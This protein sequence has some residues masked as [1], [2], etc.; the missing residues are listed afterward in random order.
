MS[1][2]RGL[3][4]ILFALVTL[5]VWGDDLVLHGR[6][7]DESGAPVRDAQVQAGTVWTGQTDPTGEFSI[8]LA[9][10]TDVPISIEREGY[11]TLKDQVV[12]VASTQEITFVIN[13]VHEVFQSENV[14]AQTS[15]VDVGQTQTEEHLSGTEVNDIPYKNSH[16]L[17]N[18]LEM[19][20]GAVQDISGSLHL[21]GAEENQVL[22]LF[23]GFN[24]NNPISGQ[25]Q[26]LLPV[27][28][29]R[30]VDLSVGQTSAEF[31]K[32]SAGVL[33]VSTQNGTDTFRYTATDFIPGVDIKQGLRIG[34]WYPRVGISGPL[35]KRRAWFTDMFQSQ[36]TQA[37]ISG[38]ASGQ[39]MRS[40]WAGS[41]ILHGQINLSSS[42][43]LFA[44]FL[45]NVDNE[46]HVGLAPLNPIGTT[47]S[48]NTRQYMGSVKD[49]K[50]FGR[51]MLLEVGYAHNY[52][53]KAILPPG[54]SLYI[55]AP[56]GNGGDYYVH[57]QQAG[58]RDHGLVQ[59]FL[60][61]FEWLGT[62]QWQIGADVDRLHYN[63]DFQRT[64]YEVLGLTGQL[65]SETLFPTPARFQ[66]SDL[67]LSAYL[68][69]SWRVSKN[70]QLS[71]GVRA[72]RDQQIGATGWSP[73]AAASWA[74]F[75]SGKTRIS[76]GYALTHDSVTMQ[77]LGQPLDQT[78]ITTN[79]NADGSVA[80][81]AAT[82]RF[83][84]P[85]SGVRLPYSSNWTAGVDQQLWTRVFLA[86]QLLRRRGKDGFAF[87]NTLAPDAPP[88]LLPAPNPQSNAVYELTNL[89]R[90]AYDSV[91]ISVRQALSG[92]YLWMAA[93]QWSRAATNAV[94]DPNSSV[95]LQELPSLVATPWDVP[96][97]FVGRGYGPLPWKNWSVSAFVDWRS[98]F[99]FSVRDQSGLIFGGVD[100]RRFPV[101]FDL[102]VAVERMITL[103]GYRFALRGGMDNVTNQ[104]NP[105]AVSRVLGT[106]NFLQFLGNEG[107]HF[108]VRIRFFEKTGK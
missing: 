17:R 25:F 31:G 7:V 42:N 37:L 4:A 78:A 3:A 62:H 9:K 99:P 88:S 41:N 95:P 94:V 30:G 60:P 86:A 5:P 76:G 87:L 13:S 46:G 10:P 47:Y 48:Q 105:T 66:V 32:G 101:N 27:E 107:R 26:T 90:D 19:L 91:R 52:F 36:Y 69:D 92:Q 67:E 96:H 73:R 24:I 59:A 11:Y 18:A 8:T 100:A 29:I 6:V 55:L 14:N 71:L 106:P 50:Y 43:I 38:L 98:G 56:E 51:G 22:Y 20:P 49:Q 75:E 68:T 57:S 1:V 97:R 108:V 93:Y 65:L 39:N 85:N 53:S 21:N 45:V 12:H 44:D 16:S 104:A 15:P 54:E 63:G 23:N 77:M 70:L 35:I 28:G 61:K 58:T 102:N 80:G 82:S 33:R 79:Y 72:D 64:G 81:T 83:A 89:R 34:N 40:G 103:R 74:P 84:A 2:S